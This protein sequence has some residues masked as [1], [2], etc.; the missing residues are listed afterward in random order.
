LENICINKNQWGTFICQALLHP[1]TKHLASGDLKT[2][3][4]AVMVKEEYFRLKDF[5]IYSNELK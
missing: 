5:N 1:L 3:L 4:S 2:L